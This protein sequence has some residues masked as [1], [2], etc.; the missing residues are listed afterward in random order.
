MIK[1]KWG[2]YILGIKYFKR[3]WAGHGRYYGTSDARVE[4]WGTALGGQGK[5]VAEMAQEKKGGRKVWHGTEDVGL[6]ETEEASC[7][8]FVY[9]LNGKTLSWAL[10]GYI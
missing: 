2:K 4:P 8:H 6:V 10:R 5:M 3:W 9:S 1:A 7:R